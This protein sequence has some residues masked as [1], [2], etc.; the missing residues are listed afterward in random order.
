MINKK[1]SVTVINEYT[2]KTRGYMYLGCESE[3]G[4]GFTYA[5]E[6][7]FLSIGIYIQKYIHK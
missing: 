5:L 2:M 1:R 6:S 4:Q 7:S 3:R